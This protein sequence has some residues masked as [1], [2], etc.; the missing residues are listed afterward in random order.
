MLNSIV[1][2]RFEIVLVLRM[3]W[4]WEETEI[5]ALVSRYVVFVY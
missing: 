4:Y 3:G 2:D 1:V 5:V